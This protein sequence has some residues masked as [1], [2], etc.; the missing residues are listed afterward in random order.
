MINLKNFEIE[1]IGV[2]LV[3]KA[4]QV[5]SVQVNKT[6]SAHCIVHPTPQAKSH[7]IPILPLFAHLHLPSTHFP[8][9][10]HHTVVSIYVSYYMIKIL[11]LFT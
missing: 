1:F 4:I 2:T 7:S 10:Y 9:G 5:S 6:S 3:H 11:F 8:S